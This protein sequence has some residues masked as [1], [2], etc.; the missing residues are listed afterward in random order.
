MNG[1]KRVLHG[2]KDKRVRVQGWF[3]DRNDIQALSID[4][5]MLWT[6]AYFLTEANPA[7]P[8]IV[9]RQ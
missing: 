7:D 8:A 4:W 1:N 3:C 2:S 9:Y 5:P 6:H